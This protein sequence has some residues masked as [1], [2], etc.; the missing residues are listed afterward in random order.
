MYKRQ[1]LSFNQIGSVNLN[2][3]VEKLD[4]STDGNW[5]NIRKKDDSLTGWSFAA[6][7]QNIAG[8]PDTPPDDDDNGN[9]DPPPDDEDKDWYRV[10]ASSLKIRMGPGLE[11]DSIG[12]FTFG[13]LVEKIG[14]S[15]NNEWLNVRNQDGTLT[16][17]CFSEYLLSVHNPTPEPPPA[18]VVPEHNT[19]NWYR[20][21]TSSL[22]IRET[23]NLNLSLIHI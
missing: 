14:A 11:F 3:V 7:L 20:V 10:T 21:N 15:P 6:Y 23:P 22:N 1:G 4:V 16:G 9:T 8:T 13:I 19:K 5:L 18:V 12:S 2:E 17:W